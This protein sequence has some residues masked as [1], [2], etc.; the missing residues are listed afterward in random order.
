MPNRSALLLTVVWVALAVP[1]LSPNYIAKHAFFGRD[2]VFDARPYLTATADALVQLTVDEISQDRFRQR[3]FRLAEFHTRNTLSLDGLLAAQWIMATVSELGCQQ[4]R[5]VTY[6]NGYTPNVLCEVVGSRP[7]LD[8]VVIGAHYDSRASELYNVTERAPG[9]DDN[10]GGCAAVI[11]LVDVVNKLRQRGVVFQRTLLFA[12]FSAEEQDYGGSM[13]YANDLKARSVNLTG[14]INVDMIGWPEPNASS[15]LYWF[16]AATNKNLTDLGLATTKL[17][18][19]EGTTVALSPVCCSDE[20]SFAGAGFPTAAVFESLSP[21]NNPNYHSSND[22]PATLDYMH[23][24]RNAQAAASLIATLAQP[25][26]LATTGLSPRVVAVSVI[27]ALLAVAVVVVFGFL[28]WRRNRRL[29]YTK[30]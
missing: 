22:L 16:S 3:V 20:A 17:Y 5:L 18:L 8:P 19:G 28:I 9:A 23:V 14:Y 4:A 25:A 27:G 29:A 24:R 2:V 1:A 15:T 6:R 10:G 13:A 30:I 12:W 11:E 26:V 7:E 21:Y